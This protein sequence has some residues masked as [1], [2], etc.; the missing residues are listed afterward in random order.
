VVNH[1]E[2]EEVKKKD[3]KLMD[4]VGES[5]G[6]RLG[7]GVILT[8]CGTVRH[9]WPHP[10]LHNCQYAPLDCASGSISGAKPHVAFHLRGKEKG[11]GNDVG[12]NCQWQQ[13]NYE[14]FSISIYCFITTWPRHHL[15]PSTLELVVS[16]NFNPS[17]QLHPSSTSI[18]LANFNPRRRQ[19]QSSSLC[20]FLLVSLMATVCLMLLLPDELLTKVII[21]YIKDVA[22][23]HFL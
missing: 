11:R 10:L 14:A 5:R 22:V 15:Q 1:E 6:G 7:G 8:R 13:P 19:L 4:E 18:L 9:L 20:Y 21:H 17:G 3:D 23:F 12:P 2:E 16:F